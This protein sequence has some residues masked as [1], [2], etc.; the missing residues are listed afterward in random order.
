M[1]IGIS[2]YI[3]ETNDSI[4]SNGVKQNAVYLLNIF[5]KIGYNVYLVNFSDAKAPYENKVSWLTEDMQ[6]RDLTES[7]KDT[8]IL[9][10]VG[11]VY[12][13]ADLKTFKE[14][15]PNKKI[16]K[17]ACG[18]NYIMDM[19]SSMF[20]RKMENAPK[21]TSYNQLID[22]LWILPHHAKTNKEYLR[23]M[24]NID[25][26]K[27]K[28]VPFVWD[29]MFLDKTVTAFNNPDLMEK[30]NEAAVPVYI[31]GK[32]NSEKLISCFEPNINVV[33]WSIIPTLIAEDYLQ[34]GGEFKKLSIF[35]GESLIKDDYYVSL[36][37]NTKI[38]N[39]DPIKINYLPRVQVA[40]ALAKFTD[41]IIA[42]QWENSLNYSYLDAL[43]L[44]FPLVHNAPMIK[45]AGYYYSDFNI[46]E[47]TNRLK[48]AIEAHDNVIE[49]YT[50]RSEKVLTRYTV[51]NDEL[52]DLHKKLIENVINPGTH[53][54]VDNYNWK[55]NVYF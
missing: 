34:K 26:D 52:V 41:I 29:P 46:A 31:P 50:E 21:S 24:H 47:G 54:L 4:W 38:F 36:M 51:Y 49:D 5:K 3:N 35:S 10:M 27:I 14:S 17:Y 33:K 1:N 2:V 20:A 40:T 43:Y 9:I 48:F 25:T 53:N 6:I 18:N 39:I 8:D 11:A 23:L 7:Y 12:S 15:G 32:N 30:L 37:Q 16:I 22:E 19:E 45:D 13:D 55:T 42:H 28:T 44:Q